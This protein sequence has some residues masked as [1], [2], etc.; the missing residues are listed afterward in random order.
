MQARK[1]G[2]LGI[3]LALLLVVVLLTS[4]TPALAQNTACY[5]PVGGASFECGDGGAFVVQD[6]ATLTVE[7]G[8]T[9]TVDSGATFAIGGNASV[10]GVLSANG[11]QLAV[12]KTLATALQG[13]LTITNGGTI[14]PTGT[15]QEITAA[16]AVTAVLRAPTN[17]EIVIL[18]N[19][20]ANNIT[21]VDEAGTALAGNWVGGQN[22]TLTLI[23]TTGSW[24]ELARSAN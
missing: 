23:G 24:Y 12:A 18:L 9:L 4:S 5:R 19:S 17:G 20:S 22:D 14:A 7:S 13:S 11:S 3:G 21:I 8:G 16:G 6:G 10:A 2:G 1:Y 15:L